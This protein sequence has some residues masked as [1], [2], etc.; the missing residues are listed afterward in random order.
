LAVLTIRDQEI[1]R[2]SELRIIIGDCF[3]ALDTFREASFDAVVTDP[4]YGLGAPPN[5]SEVLRAWLDGIDPPIFGGGFMGHDW[6]AF[7][8]SPALWRKV[9]RV[10]KPGAYAVVFAS[11]RTLDWTSLALRLAGFEV[12]DTLMWLYGSGMPKSLDAAKAID[13]RSGAERKI[14]GMAVDF[15]RD[16]AARKTDGTHRLPFA[17]QGGHGHKDRWSATVT[18]P[19]TAE[20]RRWEGWGTN[21]KPAYEPILLVRKPP[22]AS[23]IAE[24]LIAHSVGAINIGGCRI[25]VESAAGGGAAGGAALGRWPA[26]V[27]HDG[28]SEVLAEFPAAPGQQ[29]ALTGTE[30]SSKMG[31]NCYGKLDRRYAYRPRVDGGR[32]AARFFYCAKASRKDRNEGLPQ[33][34]KNT[35]PTV[36]PTK[37]MRW[38]CRLVTPSGGTLLDPF[39]G[40]G[41]TGKACR[42]EGFG[43]V[44][45]ERDAG[46]GKI[47]RA[48]LGLTG[49]LD[50]ERQDPLSK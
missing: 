50:N 1:Q 18:A 27:L 4:P 40:S 38:L 26:N 39:A 47:A 12:R 11:P 32:S 23:S 33:G 15:A 5:P 21:L 44:G 7:V 20:A 29:G 10:L 37:L 34:Q 41:S 24:N 45:I 25:P 22:A 9:F 46:S 14:I 16:G 42:L 3:T 43:F 2:M 28:S 31:A 36:K 6:D 30:P 48:R 49:V 17:D 35:H 8:P 19:A 13:K